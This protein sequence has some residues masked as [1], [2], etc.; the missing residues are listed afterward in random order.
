MQQFH[1]SPDFS[2]Q[3][4]VT[5]LE[6]LV[7]LMIMTILLGTAVSN[8][9]VLNNPLA[10]ASFSVS[11]Y[12]R[13]ARSRAISQTLAIQI[14]PSSSTTLA[15][16][17]AKTCSDTMSPMTGLDLQ[18]PSGSRL[19]DTDWSVCFTARGLSTSNVTFDLSGDSSSTRTVEIALGGG[20]RIK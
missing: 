6:I 20:V 11:H 14:A 7:T 10:N 8:L 18:L 19:L 16:S 3:R 17:S 5:L 2:C 4:G 1:P 12:L 13:L 15:A 9:K